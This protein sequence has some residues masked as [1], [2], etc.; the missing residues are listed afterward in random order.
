MSNP[1]SK[2]QTIWLT[3][4]EVM[5]LITGMWVMIDDIQFIATKKQVRAQLIEIQ[6]FNKPKPFK[7]HLRYY[8][9]YRNNFVNTTIDEIDGRYKLTLP[10]INGQ[11]SIYY[12]KYSPKTV[13]LC[14]YNSPNVGY[15]I[16]Y[17]I[18]NLI[19]ITAIIFN[20]ATSKGHSVA[21]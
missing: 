11:V 15:I 12:S 9:E 19:M 6:E 2:N 16:V 21:K 1:F 5:L 7:I 13:Y 14:D 3:S 10:P 17:G 8:N 18:F 4:L 20:F